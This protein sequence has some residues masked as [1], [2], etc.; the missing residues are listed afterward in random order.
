MKTN[1]DMPSKVPGGSACKEVDAVLAARLLRHAASGRRDQALR[2]LFAVAQGC[3]MPGTDVEGITQA[4]LSGERAIASV[5]LA[6]GV[7][8]RDG[9]IVVTN[10]PLPGSVIAAL[11]GRRVG[12]IAEWPHVADGIIRRA[13]ERKEGLVISVGLTPVEYADLWRDLST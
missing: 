4:R 3:R 13:S 5:E 7:R 10:H 2:L 8:W 12:A 9:N 11:C 1:R 6:R